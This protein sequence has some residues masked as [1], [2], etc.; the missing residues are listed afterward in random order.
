MISINTYHLACAEGFA[1][2]CCSFLLQREEEERVTSDSCCGES[3][4]SCMYYI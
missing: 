1:L 3:R 4:I 2:Q